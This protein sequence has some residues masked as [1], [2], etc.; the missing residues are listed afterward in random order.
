MTEETPLSKGER[1]RQAILEAAHGLF[2]EQGYHATSMR[3]VADRAGLALG[4]I[5]NHFAGKDEIFQELI[6]IKH[7]FVK[8][9]PVLLAVPGDDIDSFVRNAAR[10]MI[11]E[12]GHRP[13]FIKLMFI[14]LV[15]FNGQ[16]IPS[17]FQHIFPQIIP[18]VERFITSGS[19]LR[20]IPLPLLARA[21]MGMFFSFYMTEFLMG[22][23]MPPEMRDNAL[24]GFVDIFLHGIVQP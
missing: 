7:P 16:H 5:Y 14:E 13:D 21:F 2:I 12:L 3:Q 19:H 11:D 20:P 6:A 8:I 9:L 10:A 1:T 23:L 24:E 15:E 18:V 22:D 4:G 17:L